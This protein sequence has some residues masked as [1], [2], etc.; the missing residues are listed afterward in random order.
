[1]AVTLAAFVTT[2]LLAACSGGEAGGEGAGTE[3][4]GS[5]DAGSE[6]R[7][8]LTDD[9]CTYEGDETTAGMFTVEVENQ[10]VYFGAFALAAIAE[11]STID[12]LEPYLEKARQQFQRSGTLPDPPAFYS[13]VVR[14]G[15]DAGASSFLPADVPA[16][17]YALMCF[18]DDLPTWRVYV[19]AQL[20]VTE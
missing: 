11:G 3:G 12:D 17:T 5:E 9:D 4:A 16:G 20:D 19:A 15:V 7:L 10:T 13:Q 14:S 18:I 2:V 8:T 1:M 6:M